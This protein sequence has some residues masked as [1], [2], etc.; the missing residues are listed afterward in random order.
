LQVLINL[1]KGLRNEAK[2]CLS[3][4]EEISDKEES[5]VLYQNYQLSKALVLKASGLTRD[6]YEAENLLKQIAEGEIINPT[7]Y[8]LSL[9]SLCEFL[10]EELENS[11][12][13]EVINEINSVINRL[14]EIVEKQN[15][16]TILAETNLLQG[17]LALM[18]LNLNDA[19]QFLKTAQKIADEHGL[20]LL[21]QKISQEHDELLKELETWQ[22]FKKRQVSMKK[23]IKLASINSVIDRMQEKR[24]IDPP[25]LVD[26]E[27]TLL[28]IITEGGVLLFS[29]PFT[30]EWK[31]DESLFSNFLSAFTSFSDEFFSEGLDRA[32]FGQHT[33]LM[34]SVRSFSVCYLYKGQTYAAQQKLSKFIEG[35]ENNTSIWPI[36]E[37]FQKSSQILEI[38][39]S[40]LLEHLITNIFVI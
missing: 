22:D 13:L 33:V 29:H 15:S 35:L 8:I 16:Y 37:R 31:Q 20:Q 17:R 12:N 23:R 2:Q 32:K 18:M 27:A 39:D 4:L 5:K 40:P 10:L 14:L 28:L 6:R 3:L 38:K 36:L 19:R 24:A 26:E 25:E 21:A 30:D 7:I 11:N 34:E 9:V 1:D